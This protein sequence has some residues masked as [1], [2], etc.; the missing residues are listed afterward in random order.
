MWAIWSPGASLAEMQD[1]MAQIR[2]IQ[3]N[4]GRVATLADIVMCFKLLLI[5][6]TSYN[7]R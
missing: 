6:E 1:S 2:D 5:T 4:P 3:G 7:S